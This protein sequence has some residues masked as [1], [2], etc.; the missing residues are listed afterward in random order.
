[1]KDKLSFY[2]QKNNKLFKGNVLVVGYEADEKEIKEYGLTSNS[3]I[4][5]IKCDELQKDNKNKKIDY[6]KVLKDS[7]KNKDI[8]L[9]IQSECML[10]MYGD[11]HCDCE[12]QRLMMIDT[13]ANNNGIYIHMP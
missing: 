2:L 3:L 12:E 1:M 9:R 6:I 13:I 4:A 7:F 8:F 10:G 5:F 11:S